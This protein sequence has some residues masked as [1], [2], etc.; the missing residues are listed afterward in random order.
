MAGAPLLYGTGSS[1]DA[2]QIVSSSPVYPGLRSRTSAHVLLFYAALALGIVGLATTAAVLG[3]NKY[4]GSAIEMAVV[5]NVEL[6][7]TEFDATDPLQT[8]HCDQMEDNYDDYLPK[9]D[10]KYST[11]E[12]FHNACYYAFRCCTTTSNGDGCYVS[13]N[14]GNACRSCL[15][16]YVPKVVRS[17]CTEFLEQRTIDDDPTWTQESLMKD[18]GVPTTEI[19][20]LSLTFDA[21]PVKS[22]WK[23]PGN[24]DSTSIHFSSMCF[25]VISWCNELCPRDEDKSL[26]HMSCKHCTMYGFRSERDGY[27]DLEGFDAQRTEEE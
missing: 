20:S 11:S 25:E 24:Q 4:L 23:Q 13:E 21:W 27:P 14:Y 18:D 6:S 17:P 9:Y 2:E 12:D 3:G 16:R 1:G 22:C 5:N 19:E 10:K 7:A 15:T 26:Q 8:L